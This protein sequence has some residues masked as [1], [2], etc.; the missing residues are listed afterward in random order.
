MKRCPRCGQIYTD[1]LTY[2]LQD[3]AA[4]RPDQPEIEEPT[5]VRPHAAMRPE[6]RPNSVLKYV[7][8]GAAAL[9]VLG[10]VGAAGAYIILSR[11]GTGSSPI[12]NVN[13]TPQPTVT[14]EVTPSIKVTASPTPDPLDSSLNDEMEQLE[15]ELNR[16]EEELRKS[17]E[18]NR[19]EGEKDA[20]AIADAD[21]SRIEFRRGS[22]GETV[23]GRVRNS[24]SFVLRTLA[25]QTLFASVRSQGDCVVFAD[26]SA[27]IR[28]ATRQ[29]D[30]R[31]DLRNNCGGAK[32][33]RMFVT[34]R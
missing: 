30:S 3:G 17:E 33:F 28:F 10:L 8:V 12:E 22:V 14:P 25:G 26:G 19:T 9:F 24:R 16:L 21:T 5:I 27:D 29:G 23:A 6:R 34:V 2:C 13:V 31:L 15:R 11:L 1:D 20:P 4:L 18:Q 7:I 32:R